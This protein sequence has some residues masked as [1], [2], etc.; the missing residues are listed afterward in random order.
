MQKTVIEFIDREITSR[1]GISI[2]KKMIDPSGFSAYPDTLP[3]PE[4]GSN[5]GY[6]H[7]QLFLLFY[8]Q[9]MVLCGTFCSHGYHPSGYG[10]ATPVRMGTSILVATQNFTPPCKSPACNMRE[11][12]YLCP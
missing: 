6:P 3:L 10:S 11:I 5:R 9:Y 12:V 2:L 1:G 8:E 7:Q 4:Q